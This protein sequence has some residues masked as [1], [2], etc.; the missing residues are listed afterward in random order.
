VAATAAG[1]RIPP[2]ASLAPTPAAFFIPI[3]VKVVPW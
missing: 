3:T 2:T 1:I